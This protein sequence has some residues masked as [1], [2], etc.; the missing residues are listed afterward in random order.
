MLVLHLNRDV[1]L[2]K[3]VPGTEPKL[4]G[5]PQVNWN[6]DVVC[7]AVLDRSFNGGASGKDPGGT[8]EVNC[9]RVNVNPRH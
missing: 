8:G 3:H 9:Y 7:K 6:S 1:V 5:V 2:R 4:K